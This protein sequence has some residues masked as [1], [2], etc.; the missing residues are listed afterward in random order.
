LPGA[1]REQGGDDAQSTCDESK[2]ANR[3]KKGETD[4]PSEGPR[5][6]A[7]YEAC[8]GVVWDEAEG[9]TM[10]AKEDVVV[11]VGHRRGVV[12]MEG[13]KWERSWERDGSNTV[14]I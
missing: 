3:K 4:L 1:W 14:R 10:C 9:V 6:H 7:W 2:K 11:V 5:S 8:A 12:A 13:R